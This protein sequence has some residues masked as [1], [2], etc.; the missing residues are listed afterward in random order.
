MI[1]QISPTHIVQFINKNYKGN[2][3]ELPP[4][5]PQFIKSNFGWSFIT[6]QIPQ[7]QQLVSDI[8]LFSSNNLDLLKKLR[9]H[10]TNTPI[11]LSSGTDEGS[12]DSEQEDEEDNTYVFNGN[13]RVHGNT[14]SKCSKKGRYEIASN[15]DVVEKEWLTDLKCKLFLLSS[16]NSKKIS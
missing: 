3:L 6:N 12:S 16:F 13:K 9:L 11:L 15:G 4:L 14:S 2:S 8:G 1:K 10:G 5:T 7:P